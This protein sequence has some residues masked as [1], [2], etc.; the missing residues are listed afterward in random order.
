MSLW[1]LRNGESSA[2]TF[3][4]DT[5]YREVSTGNII[6][7]CEP[8]KLECFLSRLSTAAYA[9]LR[10]MGSFSQMALVCR[11]ETL[12]QPGWWHEEADKLKDGLVPIADL[13]AKKTP[14]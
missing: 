9:G 12:R 3:E 14:H 13:Q 11:L 2:A 5:P 1:H 6:G 8:L 10:A 7:G 4:L